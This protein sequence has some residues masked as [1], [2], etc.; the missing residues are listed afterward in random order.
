MFNTLGLADKDVFRMYKFFHKADV[1]GSHELTVGEL[2]EEVKTECSEYAVKVFS[3]SDTD[4][5]GSMDFEVGKARD[6]YLE[7]LAL[8][9]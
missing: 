2:C 7:K 9:Q 8:L 5:S 4:G 6:G 1:D 3:L